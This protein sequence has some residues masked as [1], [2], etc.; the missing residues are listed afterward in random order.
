MGVE[1]LVHK[2]RAA[3]RIRF[4]AATA[5]PNKL[6]ADRGPGFDNPGH[7]LITPVYKHALATV[8]L[9]TA[10]GEDARA[11]PGSLGDV[12]LHATA[13]SWLRVR[14]A[15]TAPPRPWLE[16]HEEYNQRLKACCGA[17]N[18]DLGVE[19]LCRGWLKRLGDLEAKAG[20][21]LQR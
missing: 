15:E 14:V 20:G 2:F 3:I 12:L 21:R 13:V 17:V 16:T 1:L 11:Q 18:R 19:G 7:G 10:I 9:E 5:K 4:Q 6:F 8:R